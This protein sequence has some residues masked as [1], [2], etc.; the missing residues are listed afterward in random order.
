MLI[1]FQ[2]NI[3]YLAN[4]KK[5]IVEDKEV[6]VKVDKVTSPSLKLDCFDFSIVN[7]NDTL[8]SDSIELD[9]FLSKRKDETRPSIQ[10]A[11]V[12]SSISKNQIKTT[13]TPFSLKFKDD[14]FEGNNYIK[15]S[16]LSSNHVLTHY[17][18]NEL[19]KE[20]KTFRREKLSIKIEAEISTYHSFREISKVHNIYLNNVKIK[21]P[22]IKELQK[23]V[24]KLEVTDTDYNYFKN[25]L[26]DKRKYNEE[27]F[28]SIDNLIC[29]FKDYCKEIE[30]L[31]EN[32]LFK[33]IDLVNRVPS[34]PSQYFLHNPLYKRVWSSLQNINKKIEFSVHLLE[35][36]SKIEIDRLLNIY[37]SW[38]YFKIIDILINEM[39]WTLKN[40]E[41]MKKSIIKFNHDSV[42]SDFNLQK[43]YEN[44]T[45]AHLHLGNYT[46]KVIYEPRLHYNKANKIKNHLLTPDILFEFSKNNKLVGHAIMD[47]KFRSEISADQWIKDIK[48]VAYE[49][50]IERIS[51]QI[52]KKYNIN[53][54]TIINSAII[55]PDITLNEYEYFPYDILKSK[56]KEVLNN[57]CFGKLIKEVKFIGPHKL[58]S[59]PFSPNQTNTFKNWL[60]MIMEFHFKE[61][62]V[63]WNCGEHQSDNIKKEK[64]TT[65][66]GK[67]IFHYTC[68]SCK[69]FWISTHCHNKS[70]G[71]KIY[72]HLYNY[73]AVMNR[74]ESG[75]WNI[76][77]P[78]CD[79]NLSKKE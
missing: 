76:R 79:S 30:E 43:V 71:K 18:L 25:S 12:I 13:L 46:L 24:T 63:C 52:D 64:K 8:V 9:Y 19:I 47:A 31:L 36:F 6:G 34:V 15:T 1:Y 65:L 5:E 51:K 20:L 21:K 7:Y 41:E 70:C 49:K 72:K 45:H 11:D 67:E 48:E 40:S 59:L 29:Q 69:E 73:H 56:N 74:L 26:L 28:K 2:A 75:R 39:G 50:Y 16:R 61:E 60:R 57:S 53:E 37:E 22:E 10:D 33:K 38:V 27:R 23:W 66:I 77:C 35:G 32:D 55:H 4:S 42:K 58:S 17:L 68:N 78:H 54:D 62:G 14:K 44:I 3:D